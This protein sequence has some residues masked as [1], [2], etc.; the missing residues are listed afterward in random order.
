MEFID[1]FDLNVVFFHQFL[2]FFLELSSAF[3]QVHQWNLR[4][5]V[6]LFHLISFN[7]CDFPL[8]LLVAIFLRLLILLI[9][10]F[11]SLLGNAFPFLF[12]MLPLLFFFLS[13]LWYKPFP[14]LKIVQFFFL[15]N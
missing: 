4:S 14:A 8:S 13:G 7:C 3:D 2:S 1:S 15:F 9:L 5:F 10:S 11:P 6:I 12:V